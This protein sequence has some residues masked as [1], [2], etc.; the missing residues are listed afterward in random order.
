MI[1]VSK[2]RLERNEEKIFLV[3]SEED[4]ICPECASPL[5]RRDR[6]MRIY[7]EAGGRKAG[8]PLIALNVPMR[9]AEDFIMSCRP[10][11]F[12]INIMVQKS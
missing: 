6:R 1:I 10:A 8:L 5:C 2:Y 3:I 12:L 7:K 4:A 9:N 11:C